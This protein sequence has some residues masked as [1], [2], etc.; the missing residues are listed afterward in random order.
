M[1]S[2]IAVLSLFTFYFVANGQTLDREA[3]ATSGGQF[4]NSNLSIS[5]TIGETVVGD[6]SSTNTTIS[7]GFNQAFKE[8]NTSVANL[9]DNSI[10]KVFPNPANNKLFIESGVASSVIIYN[11]LGKPVGNSVNVDPSET[12]ELDVSN[13]APGVYF[14]R[15]VGENNSVSTVKWIKK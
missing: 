5:Y 2:I 1:K 12:K 14:M 6:L 15:I 13:Y 7:Q 9:L 4:T 8:D 3:V 10:Y 11:L